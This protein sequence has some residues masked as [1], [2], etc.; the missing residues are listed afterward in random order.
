MNRG[1]RL[2]T[3][4]SVSFILCT[5]IAWAQ[6]GW[7][8]AFGSSAGFNSIDVSF[9]DVNT[10]TA[11][12]VGGQV[13]RTTDGGKRWI[14]QLSGTTQTL[15]KVH[16]VDGNTGTV[17]G[18]T[19]TILRTED[20]GAT[21]SAQA[22]GTSRNLF[23][24]AFWDSNMGMVV[25]DRGTILLTDDGGA[26]W[27]NSPSVTTAE[28]RG[29]ACASASSWAV[30]GYLFDTQ[31]IV[32]SGILLRTLDGGSSW[33][34]QTTG[35]GY[36]CLLS[37]VCF[38]DAHSGVGVG[39][40]YILGAGSN[41][42]SAPHAIRFN[43]LEVQDTSQSTDPIVGGGL[44]DPLTSKLNDVSFV[45]TN[46]GIAVGDYGAVFR[47]TDGG[48]N[49]TS[50]SPVLQGELR[51]VCF[52]GINDVY[53]LGGASAFRSTD[54]GTTWQV[55][56]G[57]DNPLYAVTFLDPKNA[58]AVGGYTMRNYGY[59]MPTSTER[60]AI[61][62]TTDGGATW[63]SREY[64]IPNVLY[65]VSFVDANNGIAV[66]GHDNYISNDLS[67]PSRTIVRTT[68]GGVSWTIQLTG[69][70]MPLRAVAF[71]GSTSATA[72]GGMQVTPAVV[73]NTSDGGATWASQ[74]YDTLQRLDKVCF[75]DALQGTAVGGS[76]RGNIIL[77]T[78]DGGATWTTQSS[79]STVPHLRG[80]F[81]SDDY[82][83]TAVGDSGVIIRTTNGGTS[84]VSQTSGTTNALYDVFFTDFNTGIAVGDHTI[85]H[86][87]NAGTT[88][89]KQSSE[90]TVP[91]L[92][93]VS[94][95]GANNGIAVGDG[96]IVRTI[97]GGVV[98]TKP[99]EE[100]IR[101]ETIVLDQNYPNP[102]NPS[103]TIRY[104]LPSRSHVTLT[105]FNTLGQQVAVLHN[106]EQEAGYQ[107][108]RFD[109]AGLSSGVYFY[110]LQVHP[111]DFVLG[112]D[113]KSGTGE[114]VETRKLLL[115]R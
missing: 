1:S 22:S 108:V 21:W 86:T 70:G 82:T 25:G 80:L 24:V 34:T 31:K 99:G 42:K 115:I 32:H 60:G 53:A 28:L 13:L 96:K 59:G 107:E 105:V 10:G 94:F 30:V 69:G 14:P 46:T 15:R 18:D 36:G 78:S 35:E 90:L 85:L 48:V 84:W 112:S 27:T 20:G 76:F 102:F 103:T 63:T 62:R 91:Y 64:G 39:V 12:G 51:G 95:G 54:R 65:G 109:G 4:F 98:W 55:L 50:V 6:Q 47:T 8:D 2:L 97:T 71:R 75:T 40:S 29:V 61:L 73:M 113:L 52:V 37:G 33:I 106:G 19:G 87:A 67:G 68:D 17:V 110:R 77:H 88:W 66:G 3:L 41:F 56:W 45:D 44:Y 104:G 16:F 57:T 49:W 23:G 43:T 111:R 11:V 26:T 79:G 9:A 100:S 5:A 7:F 58:I 101:P 81:L 114:F 74:T 72:V 93:G 92:R 38:K 89:T 83:G